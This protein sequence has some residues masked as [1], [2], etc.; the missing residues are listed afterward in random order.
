MLAAGGSAIREVPAERWAIADHYDAAPEAPGKT[1]SR[2]G[3]FL[4][5]VEAFDPLA[6]G[7]SP[8]EAEQIDPQQRLLL[9]VARE[10]LERA[11]QGVPRARK[12]G[13]F[14]GGGASEYV[15]R[16]AA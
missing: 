13:V 14:V 11:G 16:F 8:K 6:F 7:I 12:V 1:Q 15:Q 10:A 3:G 5:S 2:W 9:E 4:E